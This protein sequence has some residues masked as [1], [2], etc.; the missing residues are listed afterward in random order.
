MLFFG[1]ASVQAGEIKFT[2]NKG[3]VSDQH[4]KPRPDV[5]FSGESNDLVFHL[6]KSGVS[7]Q[8]HKRFSSEQLDN[9]TTPQNGSGVQSFSRPEN[10]M[11]SIIIHRVDINWI[12]PNKDISVEYGETI[13]GYNNY[14]LAVCPDG[15]LGVKSYRSITLK[16]VW[17]GIDIKW[18][19]RDGSLE[20][21]IILAP[22]AD[23]ALVKW[24]I[25]GAED[26]IISEGKLQIHTDLGVIGEE[27]P[28]ALQEGERPEVRQLLND[29]SISFKLDNYD[30]G[31]PIVIDPVVRLWATYY[32]GSNVETGRALSVDGNS[33]VFMVGRTKSGNLATSGAFM[34]AFQ[35]GMLDCYMAKFSSTGQR[36]WSTYIG[37]KYTETPADVVCDDL[38]N[39][40]MIM[41]IE[42][43]SGDTGLATPG[44]HQDTMAGGSIDIFL[45]KLD[46]SGVRLWSTY[47]GG[48]SGEYARTLTVDKLNNVYMA[49][50]T[51]SASGI[52]TSG[53]YQ[54][55]L[56]SSSD[57]F[58]V[59][60][61]PSGVRTWSTYYG[62]EKGD[63][64]EDIET[65]ADLNVVLAG[66][67][68]SKTGI[69]SPG[70]HQASLDSLEDFFLVKLDST[71]GR[72]WST[73]YGGKNQ[74]KDPRCAI[75]PNGNILLSGFTKSINNITT[76]GSYQPTF[77]PLGF[78][79]AFIS[80]FNKF[81]VRNWGTYFRSVFPYDLDTDGAGNIYLSGQTDTLFYVSLAGA[82]QNYHAG[83]E[84]AFVVKLD[85]NG[86]GTW[87]T[88]FGGSF[89]E[90]GF[91]ADL[92][93]HGDIY[94]TGNTGT[95]SG[96]ATFGAF[97]TSIGGGSDAFLVKFKHC[98]ANSSSIS[99]SACNKYRSPSSR[100]V[101]TAS[102]TY[103]DTLTNTEGCDSL[104]TIELT[105]TNIDDKV[106]LVPNGLES[107]DLTSNYQWI[108]CSTGLI[109]SG[110]TNRTFSPGA[111]GS[112]AV[113]LSKDFCTDTSACIDVT[114]IG[115][116]EHSSG[117]IRVYPNPAKDELMVDIGFEIESA[118]IEVM[119]NIGKVVIKRRVHKAG[120]TELDLYPLSSGVYTLRVTS[121]TRTFTRKIIKL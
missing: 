60:F 14:Y 99:P 72:L 9:S 26:L 11:D 54:P 86:F 68:D 120:P 106:N 58:V 74:E 32:G 65:D 113:V 94:L 23:V 107:N 1:L 5:L 55:G 90:L 18:Y 29:G 100:F 121:E 36:R 71:G 30:S 88:Y 4:G 52:S 35:G 57:G 64:I 17:D 85:K 114:W 34:T 62:G 109:I 89:V 108:D 15:V 91:S 112:Y 97:Q 73:Y 67:T 3:Q 12:N 20:Y 37:S 21:D 27:V 16:N 98:S 48:P 117:N 50:T 24:E 116:E 40:Y 7:Y 111:N 39:A 2:E 28:V 33:N 61:D 103:V 63:V 41:G 45:I 38:G 101:W 115:L 82:F 76:P 102:G 80:K 8:L 22:E 51:G 44:S 10:E 43:N 70:S 119:D 105:V 19:E 13:E 110:E 96:L 46:P 69:A 42:G 95:P 49:G 87:G 56:N 83:S 66:S 93:K 79:G 104:I 92:D 47:Y 31:K 25:K 53:T 59:R 78:Q 77:G 84:D 6:R 75:D 118:S 81:G